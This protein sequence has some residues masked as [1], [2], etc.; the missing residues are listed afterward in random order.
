MTTGGMLALKGEAD[1]SLTEFFDLI[2]GNGIRYW[3]DQLGKW[4]P[5]VNPAIYTDYKLTYIT[6]GN[7]AGYTLLT[8][9]IA[10]VSG[11]AN[12]DGVVNGAD[13]TIL[14]ENWQH[15]VYGEANATRE[16]GDFNGDGIVDGS[17]VT[18]LAENW[19]Y[20]VNAATTA[21]PEPSSLVLLLLVIGT[22]LIR[23]N[24]MCLLKNTFPMSK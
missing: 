7:L 19:Q 8:V 23:R 18:I 15:G 21:V 12:G 13:V 17:D 10:P 14:A 4:A 1:D 16:M 11:D 6:K 20:G 9:G 2:S 24:V 5:L 22:G 3:S